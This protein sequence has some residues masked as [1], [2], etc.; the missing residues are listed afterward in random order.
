MPYIHYFILGAV[1]APHWPGEMGE[2]PSSRPCGASRLASTCTRGITVCHVDVML[3]CSVWA[4]RNWKLGRYAG[5]AIYPAPEWRRRRIPP[6]FAVRLAMKPQAPP[7]LKRRL[8]AVPR[9]AFRD[10]TA[11][12]NHGEFRGIA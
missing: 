2:S 6:K 11:L 9:G 1:I 7:A 5:A 3:D 8:P 10:M 12:T 4:W